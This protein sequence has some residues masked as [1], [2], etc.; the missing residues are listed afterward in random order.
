ME[1]LVVLWLTGYL[2][3]SVVNKPTL[4]RGPGSSDCCR[5][6]AFFFA[7]RITH[8]SF[9]S[10]NLRPNHGQFFCLSQCFTK[11]LA[12]GDRL[13]RVNGGRVYLDGYFN[14]SKPE[15]KSISIYQPSACPGLF[16]LP[17]LSWW[18][19]WGM[20]L[21]NAV[22]LLCCGGAPLVLPVSLF[23]VACRQRTVSL[24]CGKRK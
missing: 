16:C 11:N 8:P 18:C 15:A 24:G 22:L 10:L 2:G 20:S 19:L 21:R 7:T 12:S 6:G 14:I 17:Y 9:S 13:A 5:C 1:K 4:C 3:M 23:A